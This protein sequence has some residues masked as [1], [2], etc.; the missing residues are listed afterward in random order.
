[1][2]FKQDI[3]NKPCG[4]LQSPVGVSTT[5][6]NFWSDSK[7]KIVIPCDR[8]SEKKPLSYSGVSSDLAA[9]KTNF[10]QKECIILFH[11]N[12]NH[13]KFLLQLHLALTSIFIAIL[14]DIK[15]TC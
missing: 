2:C 15:E 13:I 4:R 1:M 5:T 11:I 6:T 12:K 9:Y 10:G 7:N 3:C 14:F 8:V